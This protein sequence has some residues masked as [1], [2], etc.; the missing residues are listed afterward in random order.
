M[1][2]P[3]REQDSRSL[4]DLLFDAGLSSVSALDTQSPR[5]SSNAATSSL[6]RANTSSR[7]ARQPSAKLPAVN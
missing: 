1:I 7:I 2:V 4:V 6:G 5:K 3:V